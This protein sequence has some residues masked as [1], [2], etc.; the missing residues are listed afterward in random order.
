MKRTRAFGLARTRDE[1]GKVTKWSLK[2]YTMC[3]HS[4]IGGGWDT[5]AVLIAEEY[6]STDMC[7]ERTE[8]R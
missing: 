2:P 1:T 4:L 3:L 5:M 7:G 6:E 8:E